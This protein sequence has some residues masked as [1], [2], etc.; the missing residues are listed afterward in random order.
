MYGQ[1]IRNMH[2]DTDKE[3]S[4]LC[5]RKYDLK[6]PTEILIRTVREKAIRTN[7]VKYHIDKS[8]D[9]PSCEMFGETS[10]TINHNV[11]EYSK[12]AQRECKRRHDNVARMVHSKLCKIFSLENYEKQYLHNPQTVTKN[13]NLGLIWD[14]NIQF[15]NVTM[16]RRPDIVTD[17][18]MDK[19]AIIIDVAV[20]GDK[21]IIDKEKEEIQKQ[22][23]LK[24]EI[25]RLWNLKKIDVI[26]VVL[27]GSWECYKEL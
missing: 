7:Y 17:N 16:E 19:T 14:M 20:P 26:P 13:L 24:R 10:K 6:I 25:Q 12:L 8:V 2:E 27:G 23:N 11:I 3:K 1:F 4:W 22:Q 15:D 21:K 5:M 9:S 18:K